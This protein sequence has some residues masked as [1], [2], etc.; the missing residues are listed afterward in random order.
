MR[1]VLKPPLA[2]T[3]I[4]VL[5]TSA[6]LVGF[7]A[8]QTRSAPEP[9][10]DGS[11]AVEV[12]HQALAQRDA[13]I[14][15]LTQRVEKLERLVGSIASAG[16][17]GP[18]VAAL[19]VARRA[20]AQTAAAAPDAP[21]PAAKPAVSQVASVEP[22]AAAPGEFEVD[23]EAADRA[24]ERT[25][26]ETGALLLPFGKAE[27]RPS[28]SYTR[29]EA[30]SLVLLV[31]QDDDVFTGQS[32]ARR[33]EFDFALGLRVGLPLDAQF[34][35]NLPFRVVDQSLSRFPD[36]SEQEDT[37]SGLGDLSLG[38]AKT[39]LR[40]GR[41]WPDLI[42]RVTWDTASGER[43]D[44]EV[45]LNGDFDEI[46]GSLTALK[47]QDP[48]AFIGAVSYETTFEQDGV[49][50]GDEL[51]F[52][53]GTVLAASPETSLRLA[54]SQAFVQEAE[55]DGGR[56]RGSDQV[57]ASLTLGAAAVLGRGLLVDVSADIGLTDDAPDYAISVGLPIRFDLPIPPFLR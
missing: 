53:I 2:R 26:V 21:V 39:L 37:G 9:A 13:V 4:V 45:V 55:I 23:E 47:R 51:G 1:W 5:L 20:P 16:A 46:Q 3:S 17:P 43:R 36:R 56:I 11:T 12:L 49:D 24:L 25:L 7:V 32:E 18:A 40:E 15:D 6:G 48:L 28:F 42:G 27:L 30:E 8:A 57:M 10:P 44:N 54:L 33:N 29:D 50:P 52:S 19:P 22:A 31:D 14:L 35:L 38:L 41:W 34:E